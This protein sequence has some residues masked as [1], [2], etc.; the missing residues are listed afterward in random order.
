MVTHFFVFLIEIYMIYSVVLIPAVQQSD[1]RSF[2][3]YYILAY[4]RML[5]MALCALQPD[6][7][8]YPFYI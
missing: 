8:V 6:L 3:K 2:L 7:V 1:S 5:D 4:H